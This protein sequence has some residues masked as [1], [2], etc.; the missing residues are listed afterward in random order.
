MNENSKAKSQVIDEPLKAIPL[1]QRQHWLTPA[2]IF[3]GLEFCVP[4]MMIGSTLIGSFSIPS[5]LILAIITMLCVT[6]PINAVSGYVG[7]K[8]GKSS[9]VSARL[10]FGDKQARF[11][12]GV[13][14][15]VVV[16]GHWGMQTAVAGNAICALLGVDYTV[17]R[18]IWAIVTV[19]VGLIFAI[20]SIMGYASMKWTDYIAV[21][22]GL[23]LCI[24]GVYLA[25]KTTGFHEIMAFKP[26][27]GGLSL[28]AGINLIASLNSAQ[29]VIAMDYTRFAKPTWSDNIKIPFG[30]IGVGLPLIMVG[31]MMAIGNGTPDIVK[32]MSDLGFPVW[33]FLVLWLSTWTSQLVNNYSA[34]LS[35]ANAFNANSNKGRMIVTFGATLFATV[36]ALMGILEH[37]TDLYAVTGLVFPAIAGVIIADFFLREK[38]F[39]YE[40]GDWNWMATVAVAVGGL[41]GFL[42]TYVVVIGIPVAQTLVVTIAIYYGIMKAKVGGAKAA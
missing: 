5:I 2:M 36:L 21:P 19:A 29:S 12:V 9:S 18:G 30:I 25:F 35:L 15:A 3:G 34:G 28:I 11:L 38:G 16:L 31:S 1:D 24:F 42:T 7:A 33:G 20:P 22:A 14:I 32:V 37:L 26:A 39:E 6:L 27:V 4:V 17:S 23:L 40:A 8:T 41:V 13:A 10:C